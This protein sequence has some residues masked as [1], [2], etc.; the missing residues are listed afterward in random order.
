MSRIPFEPLTI[1]RSEGKTR[2]VMKIQEGCDRYC[3]YCI[4]PYV[5]GTIRSRPL[6]A[7]GQE[8][9]RLQQ[10]GYRE[11]VLTGIHLSSYGRDLK[12]GSSL[13]DAVQRVAAVPGIRRIRLG[14]LEPV[15]VDEAFAKGLA[16][17]NK[18]CPQFHLSLQSG[19][20]SVLKRMRRRYTAAAYLEAVQLLRASFPDC[21]LTTDV[22]TG[23]P[24][25]TGEEHRE[26]LQFCE[27]V[28]FAKM[29][30]FPYSVREG[31]EA[32]R[33]P[34]QLPK[35]VKDARAA[36]LIA[37]GEGLALRYRERLLGSVQDVLFETLDQGLAQGYSPQYQAVY[38]QGVKPGD[39]HRVLLEALH[40]DGFMGRAIG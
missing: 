9:A 17:L 1:Q 32:A 6:E 28:G 33:M 40:Q 26:T 31:T 10:A 7:I 38:C 8:A 18:V 16:A 35:Q 5:R 11:L 15:V 4:I 25:E 12:D 14:S 36:E 21:A 23:F 37:L 34:G 3:A 22:L 19:S 13:L 39:I 20:D 30:V 24:G 2:A 29:H 27:A